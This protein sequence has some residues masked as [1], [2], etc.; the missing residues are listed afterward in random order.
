MMRKLLITL[1]VVLVCSEVV[2]AQKYYDPET[3]EDVPFKERLYF[4]GNFGFQFGTL[5]NIE[6]SPLVGYMITPEFSMGLGATFQYV[7]GEYFNPFFNTV[8][9]YDSKIYGGRVFGRYNVGS[10]LFLY[11]EFESISNEYPSFDEDRLVREWIPGFFVGGGYTQSISGSFG[12]NVTILY[13]LA[14]D[15]IKSPY[16]SA[17]VIRGGFTL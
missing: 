15:D 5:T 8:I 14:H 11:T 2:K 4:G 1:A 10:D 9:K 6:V 3:E 16:G 7:K 13:N 12:F 17:W